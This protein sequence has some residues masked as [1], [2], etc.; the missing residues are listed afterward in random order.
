MSLI[1]RAVWQ[2]DRAGLVDLTTR[3]FI[4]WAQDKHGSGLV[5]EPE[6]STSG[7]ISTSMRNIEVEEV[8]AVEISLTENLKDERWMTRQRV[9]SS[10]DGGQWIWVD[11]ERVADQNF[12]L[13]SIAAPRLVRTHLE[14]G[15]KDGGNPRV[16]PVAIS[17]VPWVTFA[18]GKS[19]SRL[20]VGR[21]IQLIQDSHR[22]I[23]IVVFSHDQDLA[24]RDTVERA[25]VTQEMIAGLAQVVVLTPPAQ[26]AF[27][28]HFG[29]ALSVWDGAARVYLPGSLEPKRHRYYRRYIVDQHPREVGR[30]IALSLSPFSA[31]RR[32]PSIYE[33]V[34]VQ[35]RGVGRDSSA[36]L[37]SVAE[38]EIEE[39]NRQIEDLN[40]ELEERDILLL[41]KD[42]DIEEMDKELSEQR[43][44]THYWRQLAQQGSDSDWET[45]AIPDDVSSLRDA[46]RLCQ[47][48][49]PLVSLPDEAI[50]DLEL[51][52]A[53]PEAQ[54]WARSSWR[55]F[56]ALAAY[57][58]ETESRSGGFWQWCEHS[59][60]PD[61]WPASSKKLSMTESEQVQN[62][63]SQRA[64][65]EL[66]VDPAVH[67]S[68]KIEMFAHLKIAEG[69]G[70]NIPRIYFHDDTKG[71]TGKVH[72]G[73]FGP[74][75]Y[76]ENTKT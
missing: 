36:D 68:G 16:G 26:A 31:A 39:R 43:R 63:K 30:R 22:S 17:N 51:L 29:D 71:E 60:N 48:L 56:R 69:G 12:R 33:R 20:K 47:E 74:H 27:H 38:L 45:T 1:Y 61:K 75:S 42:I 46:A 5:F 76:M 49:L 34:R 32:A 18:G 41:N 9:M 23:P 35:L 6:P 67:P 10:E 37:I 8:S 66:T 15:T 21:L 54:A 24:P 13:P 62:N 19:S 72:V 11:V 53:A 25:K 40:R 52:E 3:T 64:A 57:A 14:S 44:M 28:Q 59:H 7:Q 65:R 4:D 58:A 50:R 55:A 2:D 73:F 70:T